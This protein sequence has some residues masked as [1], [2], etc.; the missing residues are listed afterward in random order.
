MK[1]AIKRIIKLMILGGLVFG[2]WQANLRWEEFKPVLAE[3]EK[4]N[5]EKYAK[6]VEEAKS[7][8]VKETKLLYEEID[9][10][11]QEEVIK[12]RYDK[13]HEKRKAD[14]KFHEEYY[15]EELLNRIEVRK[16]L[17]ED[18][19]SRSKTI[20]DLNKLQPIKIRFE[21]WKKS[22]VWKQRLIL[23]EKCVKYIKIEMEDE[24]VFRQ[25]LEVSKVSTLMARLSNKPFPVELLCNDLVPVAK[26]PEMIQ[27][28]ILRLNETLTYPYFVELLQ[29]VGIPKREFVSFK[30][31]LI[32]KVRD[33]NDS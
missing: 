25:G 12:L 1:K 9:S 32:G 22:E 16:A 14:K 11:T 21:E 31:E 17:L 30:D 28:A 24:A 26:S 8:H 13:W 10:M 2:G 19:Q 18:Y 20:E 5:P 7:F 15:D 23:H 6:M 3:L 33:Y 29:E 27:K 4:K